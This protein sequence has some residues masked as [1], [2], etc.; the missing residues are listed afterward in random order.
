MRCIANITLLFVAINSEN[1][2]AA[3]RETVVLQNQAACEI[4]EKIT[5]SSSA[6]C[7][8]YEKNTLHTYKVPLFQN[9]K[10]VAEH[11]CCTLNKCDSVSI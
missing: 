10:I 2:L 4:L 8:K 11:I 3:L 5:L 1:E 9:P 6:R 7:K